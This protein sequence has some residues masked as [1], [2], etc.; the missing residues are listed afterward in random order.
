MTSNTPP[1]RAKYLTRPRPLPPDAIKRLLTLPEACRLAKVS[2]RS[3][4]NWMAL[5]SLRFVRT[6][7]GTRRVYA[8]DLFRQGE[9][10]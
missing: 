2:R 9:P 10:K 7:G 1:L 5:G 8:D 4:Y 3:L 6:P